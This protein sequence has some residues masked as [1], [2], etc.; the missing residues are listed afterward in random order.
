[1]EYGELNSDNIRQCYI[2]ISRQ[3]NHP[4][5]LNLKTEPPLLNYR[6]DLSVYDSLLNHTKSTDFTEPP[7]TGGPKPSTPANPSS[8]GGAVK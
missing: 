8:Q 2:L 7:V 6:P 4:Q 5:P 3:E 1:L